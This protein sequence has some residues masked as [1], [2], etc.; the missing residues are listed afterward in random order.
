MHP[1][2][3]YRDHLADDSIS[4][5]SEELLLLIKQ[6]RPNSVLEFGCGTG[7]HLKAL[8][9]VNKKFGIDVSLMNIIHGNVKNGLDYL[10]LGDEDILPKLQDID[11][12]F[13]CSVLD[14]IEN[15][16]AIIV[17]MKR[18]AQRAIY[19][20]ETLD[21][22]TQFYYPHDYESYGFQKTGFKW[23]SEHGDGAV[24]QIW[25]WIK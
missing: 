7:K 23:V 12:V 19:L 8:P 22:P 9:N 10:F 11:V 20:A 2:K 1:K 17:E 15:I 3:F 13:T 6:Q 16:D 25:K 24:Y 18:I 21:T 5:L 14:H 4:P